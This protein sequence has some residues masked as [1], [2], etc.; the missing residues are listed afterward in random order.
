M[1]KSLKQ[2]PA[3]YVPMTHNP[4]PFFVMSLITLKKIKDE[5]VKWL[6]SIL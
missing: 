2:A 6:I 5:E 1:D 3:T 4:Q